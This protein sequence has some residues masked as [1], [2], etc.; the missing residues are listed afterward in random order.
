MSVAPRFAALL[1]T[2]GL[3]GF[4][5]AYE[6]LD[7][8]IL[9]QT[10]TSDQSLAIQLVTKSRFSHCGVLLTENGKPMVLE[11]VGPVKLTPM[12][13]WIS[14][15]KGGSV[16]VKRLRDAPSLITEEKAAAL[17]SLG[18]SYLGRPYDPLFEWSDQ[19]IYCSELV[20]KV[21]HRALGIE[22]A[23]LQR[24]GSLDLGSAEAQRIARQRWGGLP[25]ANQLIISPARLYDS[26]KL[27]TVHSR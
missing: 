18:K 16:V 1:L 8:D 10:S 5:T 23:S 12:S 6:P 15:G 25:P 9:F 22:L 2:L 11:A 7:G 26:P 27:V 21:Y 19:A 3:P 14:R 17:R 13:T 24:I 20:H 4:L